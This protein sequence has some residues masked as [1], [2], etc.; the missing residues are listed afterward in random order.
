MDADALTRQ[1]DAANASARQCDAE[2]ARYQ[3]LA[4]AA[5]VELTRKQTQLRKAREAKAACVQ[6]KGDNESFENA[7]ADYGRSLDGALDAS[8]IRQALDSKV[9]GNADLASSAVDAAQRLIDELEAECS[10][11]Q[12]QANQ[13]SSQAASA[14]SRASTWRNTADNAQRELDRG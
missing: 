13:Y 14:R 3:Q 7:L 11:L 1:R 10:T 12:S 4:N 2:A 5:L 8:D 6:V 9:S